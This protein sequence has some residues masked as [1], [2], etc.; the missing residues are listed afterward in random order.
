MEGVSVLP[1]LVLPVWFVWALAESWL[2]QTA[3]QCELNR[4]MASPYP[5]PW[6]AQRM[7]STLKTDG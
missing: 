2:R 7:T 6:A 4:V 3:E 5:Y 1:Q